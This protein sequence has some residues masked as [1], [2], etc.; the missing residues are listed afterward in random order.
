[1][2]SAYGIAIGRVGFIARIA[3]L[4]RASALEVIALGRYGQGGSALRTK[5][6]KLPGGMTFN[7]PIG[8]RYILIVILHKG[9]PYY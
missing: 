6:K 1:V 5:T 8:K 4:D 7:F 2:E 9:M 3:Q